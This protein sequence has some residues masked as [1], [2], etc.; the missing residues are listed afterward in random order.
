M[1]LVNQLGSVDVASYV[2]SPM[3]CV[4]L[5]SFFFMLWPDIIRFGMSVTDFTTVGHIAILTFLIKVGNQ[6]GYRD[7]NGA[8]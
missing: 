2:P 4:T 3:N 6:R 7:I 5:W 8:H 1:D